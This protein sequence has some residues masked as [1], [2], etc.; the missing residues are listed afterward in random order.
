MQP[1]TYVTAGLRRA[2]R[3]RYGYAALRTLRRAVARG[4]ARHWLLTYGDRPYAG[5]GELERLATAYG[6]ALQ[7]LRRRWPDL[8]LSDDRSRL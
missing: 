1:A 5:A 4:L 8:D 2:L 3:R 7:R 6:R